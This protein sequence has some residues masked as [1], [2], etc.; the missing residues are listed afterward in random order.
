MRGPLRVKNLY[1][2][3]CAKRELPQTDG[4][5]P[6]EHQR[7]GR[8]N[9]RSGFNSLGAAISRARLN[10]LP[11][12]LRR[13]GSTGTLR[14]MARQA[15]ITLKIVKNVCPTFLPHTSANH[16]SRTCL[17]RAEAFLLRF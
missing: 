11:P 2:H 8:I 12:T 17:R 7:I 16:L 1:P 13:G 14:G 6:R 5:A 9:T 3:V 10:C 15:A 4:K